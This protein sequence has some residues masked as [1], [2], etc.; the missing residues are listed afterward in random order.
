MLLPLAN[1][2]VGSQE[3]LYD[4]VRKIDWQ[5]HLNPNGTLLVDFVGTSDAIRNTQFGAVKVKDAIVDCIRDASGE[6]PSVA[7]QDP[8]LRINARLSR[9][10]VVVSL[11]LSGDSLHRRGYRLKQGS[12]PMKE[13][14]AA[15]ILLR[16]GWPEIAAAGGALLDPMC[17]SGT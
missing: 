11:D 5:N 2:D 14:L 12:A 16:A 10:K 15:G 9:D 7:K 3:D 4:G 13:N 1:F 8:D 17:G 6:R